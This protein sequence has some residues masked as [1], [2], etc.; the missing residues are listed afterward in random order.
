MNC[1]HQ[2]ALP[3]APERQRL[4]CAEQM[5]SSV[6]LKRKIVLDQY[7]TNFCARR[8]KVNN[9]VFWLIAIYKRYNLGPK[10]GV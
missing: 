2:P 10:V 9:Y 5:L 4:V 3:L 7:H 1:V 8:C 6:T